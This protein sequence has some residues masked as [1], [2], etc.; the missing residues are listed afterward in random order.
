MLERAKVL[1]PTQPS[2]VIQTSNG[3]GGKHHDQVGAVAGRSGSRPP[4]FRAGSLS[5]QAH[6]RNWRAPK[7]FAGATVQSHDGGFLNSAALDG[8]AGK[9]KFVAPNH[10][11]TVSAAFDFSFPQDVGVGAP[12]Q[13]YGIHVQAAILMGAAKLRPVLRDGSG[14]RR[15]LEF[16]GDKPES[17]QAPRHFDALPFHSDAPLGSC[18]RRNLMHSPQRPW[19]V[20]DDASSDIRLKEGDRTGAVWRRAFQFDQSLLLQH[21]RVPSSRATARRGGVAEP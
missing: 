4:V 15:A 10:W 9:E 16:E 1:V 8:R 7:L 2:V 6:D 20:E 11:R 14:G 12:N 19:I 18:R 21:R 17:E 3:A 5:G 13:W